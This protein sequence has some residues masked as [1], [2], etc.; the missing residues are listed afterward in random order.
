MGE[1]KKTSIFTQPDDVEAKSGPDKDQEAEANK[2]LS[3]SAGKNRRSL[4]RDIEKAKL[5]LGLIGEDDLTC[6]DPAGDWKTHDEPEVIPVNPADLSYMRPSNP[7]DDGND[8]PF[9]YEM[10]ERAGLRKHVEDD[11]DWGRTAEWIPPI[12]CNEVD[13]AASKVCTKC[14]KRVRLEYFRSDPRKLD[15]LKSWCK[16]CENA[17]ALARYTKSRR[18]PA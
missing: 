9:N 6:Y 2:L 7:V 4:K 12:G 3:G 10:A 13:T 17:A 15:G 1:A 14:G 5:E 11:A 8:R 16:P 18:R